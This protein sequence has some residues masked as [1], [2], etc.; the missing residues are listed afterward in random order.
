MKTQIKS[1]HFVC[2]VFVLISV[3]SLAHTSVPLNSTDKSFLMEAARG[4]LAEA[5][6]GKLASEQGKDDVVNELGWQILEDY[7]DANGSLKKIAKN[8]GVTLPSR[9]DAKSTALY[10]RLSKLHGTAFDS[11]YIKA[12]EDDAAR[13]SKA[14]QTEAD[15]GKDAAVKAFA[16]RILTL[17]KAQQEW[18][19]TIA[20]LP[21]APS[22]SSP[23]DTK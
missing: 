13:M 10:A 5:K 23:K 18:I 8:K 17:I 4:G 14:F 11:A 20:S 3:I 22:A 9:M 2:G 7:T 1:T 6:L 16:K 15:E 19:A 21:H 12:I